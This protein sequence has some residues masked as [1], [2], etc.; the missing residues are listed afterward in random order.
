M[1][2]RIFGRTGLEV[3][4]LG[5]GGAEIGYEGATQK[6]VDALLNEALDGGL[7]VIDTAECYMNS[8]ELI[9]KAVGHRRKDYYLFTKCGHL[10]SDR[11]KGEDWS[12]EGILKS[13]QQSLKRLKTDYV[14]LV[15]L[16]SC[17]RAELEKGECI[18]ALIEARK[19][20]YTKLI[21]YSGD[22]KGARFAVES[23]EFEVLQTSISVA[24][25]EALELTLPLA[26]ERGMGVIAKR[27]IANA[28]WRHEDKPPEPYHHEYWERFQKLDYPFQRKP[29]SEAV[30]I[31]M[32]YTLSVQGVHTM[33]VGTKKPG[34][35]KENVDIVKRG[36]LT[37]ADFDA[38]RK[39][40]RDVTKGKWE[41]QI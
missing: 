1:E 20:G 34:R 16:H 6:D 5:F 23:S 26:R 12:K 7:N 22:S 28:A 8:E 4:L 14:D 11:A 10:T 39:R 9:G 41:G 36:P 25:Q 27:P 30:E 31:A 29:L 3:S 32:R 24:D 13:V 33:I 18:D 35:W 2:K 40:W 17:S 38:I 19:K 21:G 37:K 15:C